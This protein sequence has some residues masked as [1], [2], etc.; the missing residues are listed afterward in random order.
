MN[1]RDSESHRLS[2][3]IFTGNV[4]SKSSAP[5]LNPIYVGSN[6]GVKLTPRTNQCNRITAKLSSTKSREA[7]ET[8]M[9]WIPL[10]LWFLEVDWGFKLPDFN[11]ELCYF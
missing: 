5:P 3:R 1:P 8:A 7:N 10:L 11:Y 9:A 2:K 6:V 4:E